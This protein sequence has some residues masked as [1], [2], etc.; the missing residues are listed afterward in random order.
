MVGMCNTALTRV[1][2][3]GCDVG[4]RTSSRI[5]C[6]VNAIICTRIGD[7]N[8]VRAAVADLREGPGLQSMPHQMC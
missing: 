2:R 5:R 8:N 3:C 4:F 1:G 6:T 7:Y